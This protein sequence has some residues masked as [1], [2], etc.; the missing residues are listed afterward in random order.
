VNNK[1]FSDIEDIHGVIAKYDK[2]QDEGISYSEFL[3]EL[4]PKLYYY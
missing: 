2:N 3:Q 4:T 1:I